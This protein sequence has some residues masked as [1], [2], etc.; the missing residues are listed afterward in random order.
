[1][2][3][4]LKS[5]I[6]WESRKEIFVSPHPRKTTPLVHSCKKDH[7]APAL[8]LINQ[9]L[10]YLKK[11]NYGP[12]KIVLSLHKFPVIIFNNDVIEERTSRWVN[13][14]VK[15]FN[16]YAR[17]VVEHWKNPH[18]KIFY[19]RKQKE[20]GKS[21]EEIYS[22]SK[23]VQ[24]I[25]TYWELGHE[26]KFITK[27]V[28]RRANDCIVPDYA[29]IGL[30][31]SLS[32]FIRG[33]VIWERVHDF[34]LG[35]ESYQQKVNLTAPTM[36][37][38]GIK[39]HEMFSI[40]YEPVHGIIYKNSKKEKW[41]MRHS[42]IHKFCDPTLN[43]VLEGLK[44]YN[45]DVKYGYVQKDHTKEEAEYLKLF[46]E[47][48]E[49]R[50]KH[51]R[52]VHLLEDKQIPS[53]G[54]F[55]EVFSNCKAF[56]GN[57]R[58]SGSFGEETDKT[59]NL[60]QHLLRISSQKLETSSQ[61]TRDAVI[62]HLK[63]ASQ[64]LKIMPPRMM[65][66]SAGWLAAASRGGGTGGQTG[67]GGDRT[68]GRSG[69]QGNSRND[70]QGGQVGGQGREVNDGVDRVPNFSTIIAHH[71]QN[72]LPTIVA[73][74][75]DQG[76]GHGS[77]RNQNGDAINDN[78]RD[79]VR[80]VIE[81]NDRRGCTNKEFLACKPK[82]YNGKG[83]VVVYTRWVEK[84]ESVQDMNGC[85]DNQKVNYTAGSFVNKALTWWNS[86]I[87]TLGQEKL[88][89]ELW[90]H[91]MVGA[92]HVAYN[93]RFHKLA[94]LVP[95]LVTP[96]NRRIEMYVYGLAPQ[97][98]GMVAA[99]E[100]STIQKAVQI[101][102]TL[103]DEALRNGGNHQNQVVAVNEGQGRRNNGN[104]ARGRAFMLG[105][106]EARQDPNIMTGTFT[107]NNHYA[108]TLFDSGA[109]YGF[110]STTFIPL[111]CIEPNDLGFSYEIEIAS[112][113]LVEIDKVIKGRN[114]LRDCKSKNSSTG[115]K[116]VKKK[117]G[118][119][120]M[121]IDYRELNKLTIKNRYPL[122]RIYDLLDQIQ[123]AQ[124]FSKIDLR[125]G[126]HQLRVHKDD[127]PKTAFRTQVQFLRHRINGD[128]IHVDPSKIKA[129]KN[130]KA[131]R[132][133][134]KVRSFLG[135]AGYYHRFIENFSKIAKPLTVLTQKSKT[136][137]WG[138]EQ[139]NAF[140]TLKGKLCDAVV[141]A[142]LDGLEDFVV[143]C[144][145]SGLG[146][147]GVLMQKGKVIAYA[148][149]LLKIHE[150]NYTTHDLELGAVVF[151]LKIWRHYLY[152]TKS[153]IY[154]DHKSLQHI[155]SQ[156]ELNMRQRH[157]IELFSDYDYEI[158]YH[159]GKANVVNDALNRKERVKP[160]RVLAMNMTLQSSIKDRILA[161][162]KEACD[163]STGLQKGDVRTLIMDEADKLK[164]S[165]HSGADKMYYDLRDRYW[166]PGMK[167][168]IAVYVSMCLTCLKVKVEHQRWSSLLQ[169]P[170]I[171]EWKWEG[172]SMDFVTKLPRTSSGH[173]TIWVIVDRLTKS[174]HFLSMRQDYKMDRLAEFYLNEIVAR[175]GVPILIISDR[176]NRFSSRFWQS[177]QE[178][179]GTRLDMKIG[180]GQLIGPELVQETTEKISQIKDRLKALRD[181][182]KSYTNKRR[183]PLEFIVGDYVLLKVSPWKGVVH[184]GKKKKLAPRFVGPFKII[185]KIVEILKREF[186]KL[187]RSRIAIV[188]VWWNSKRGP[189]FTWECEDQMK[190][191]YPHLFSADK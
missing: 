48:I 152:G 135:L 22:N 39:D 168:D 139:E 160:N 102:G 78:I 155:F 129:V 146:L 84:M 89:T 64:D 184:F 112:G 40:I 90:N 35:I 126:Y 170:E 162:Q 71:L 76:R 74:V 141:L 183:K 51:P 144:D 93:D 46:E 57:T 55:D 24:V 25:K 59:T 85:G 45:N 65:T 186:K 161:A 49:E 119:F 8:S 6:V 111:L 154:T 103:T 83:G 118:S 91:D 109:D 142:L 190:L 47:E 56:G 92:D 169:Q 182:L 30:L 41:V 52:K 88:E 60:H 29:N 151:A 61:I 147:G 96:E 5:D 72:L 149:R 188:K 107:L 95:H 33:T 75:G 143:F 42:E 10:L 86:Q 158:R 18:A 133:L 159:P 68:G 175:H 19:I 165:L 172:I 73:Q 70:D 132:T 181:R 191:K 14:C 2:K 94:R 130:W 136:F 44:S 105:A 38:L 37:F 17:Y 104:Q 54:I 53:V 15:K 114:P 36:T 28:A 178:A 173:D 21:K 171:P 185:E 97:I 50:L 140:Q 150:K 124:Y 187:K 145:A 137:D 123:G 164:Y 67:R 167:K 134:S 62:T 115:L 110:V 23:I 20:L 148:C 77:G 106:E 174:A 80:N 180:E 138:E 13:K 128:G 127:I 179:L 7:E 9:D 79:D 87:H 81:N 43:R 101:A 117:D 1:M 26:H 163:E 4:F 122:P 120:R 99:M 100:P 166:W 153:V 32:V 12:E 69:D 157:W 34:Q 156:K 176:D 121:C 82:E 58:D 16:P 3:N 31:W 63:T 98:R 189:E 177:M 113:Q 131:P 11:G 108:T 116:F 66:R 27:I 125:S